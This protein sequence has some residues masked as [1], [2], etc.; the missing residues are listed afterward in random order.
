MHLR[1]SALA[2]FRGTAIWLVLASPHK[3]PQPANLD[4]I[5]SSSW[6]ADVVLLAWQK[7]PGC[8]RKTS[9]VDVLPNTT[10]VA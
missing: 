3:A 9:I 7:C 5:W 1:S 8:K 2:T 10:V 6:G 4:D